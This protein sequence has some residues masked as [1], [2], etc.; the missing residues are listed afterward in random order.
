VQSA[1]WASQVCGA[2]ENYEVLGF[3]VHY[4][5]RTNA[6]VS[7]RVV[8][9]ID[10]DATDAAP[11]TFSQVSN[12]DDS[13]VSNAWEGF[14]LN[15]RKPNLLN[16]KRRY[17]RDEPAVA[18]QDLRFTDLG[19]L[20]V[21]TT[22]CGVTSAIGD[23]FLEWDILLTT[24]QIRESSLGNYGGYFAGGGTESA[25][26]PLG[27]VPVPDSGN[28]GVSLSAASR[29]SYSAVGV[30][31]HSFYAVGTVLSGLSATAGSSCSVSNIAGTVTNAGATASL[32]TFYVT[33]SNVDANAYIDLTATA[34]TITSATL[35]VGAVPYYSPPLALALEDNGCVRAKVRT[36]LALNGFSVPQEMMCPPSCTCRGV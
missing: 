23:I 33:V 21:F 26:N 10:Y 35:V 19:K 2:F 28:R 12:Y 25:A 1:P 27:T 29:L 22:G 16:L 13:Y 32:K 9:A 7:G 14:T 3:S 20:Y 5:P 11:T 17:V 34:T 36:K 6:T 4:A 24:P 15:A 31:L 30:Y 18:D 8:V